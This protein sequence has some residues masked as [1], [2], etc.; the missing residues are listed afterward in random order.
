MPTVSLASYGTM[1]TKLE[2]L[3]RAAD[4]SGVIFKRLMETIGLPAR[5]TSDG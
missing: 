3:T 2:G 1:C 4:A 5:T